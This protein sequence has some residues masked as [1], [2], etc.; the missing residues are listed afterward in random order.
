MNQ[1]HEPVVHPL[2]RR[3]HLS[4]PSTIPPQPLPVVITRPQMAQPILTYTLL[5]IN[6]LVFILD[7]ALNGQLTD[8]GAKVNQLIA[9]GEYWRLVTPIFLHAGML[10]VGVNAYSLYVLGPAIERPFGQ[11]RFLAIY[12]LS[13]IAGAIA[14]FALTP[15][16]SIGASGAIFGL[17]GG[18]IPFLFRNRRIFGEDR[19]KRQLFAI[20]RVIALNL[21]IG[22][23][24][25]GL[26]DNWCH[27]GGLA[28]GLAASWLMTPVYKATRS[29][30]GQ[31]ITVEDTTPPHRLWITALVAGWLLAAITFGIILLRR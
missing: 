13:G 11:A 5:G 27:L 4:E 26:I 12:M 6:I 3:P 22:F 10:H 16:P 2:E 15:N 29:P 8:W 1:S 28:C 19:A 17:A 25:A 18:L 21:V 14:S 24:A 30:D 23:V 7:M 20:L 31:Q 9:A